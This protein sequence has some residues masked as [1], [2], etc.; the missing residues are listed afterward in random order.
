MTV[1]KRSSDSPFTYG[2]M[3]LLSVLA[4]QAAIAIKNAQLFEEIQQA[5]KKVEESDYLKSEFI[6]I[7]SHELRTPLVSILGY[8]EIL[9]SGATGE[10]LEYLNIVLDQA[11]RLRSVVNDLLSLTDLKAGIAEIV[12]EPISLEAL[13]TKIAGEL[14]AQMEAKGIRLA[15]TIPEECATIHADYE[16]LGLALSKLLSNAI[17]FSP[18]GAKVSVQARRDDSQVVISVMDRGKG[19]PPEAQVNL[20][21]PFYQVE[22]SLRRTHSGMGLG[23]AIAKG[24]IELHG[25]EI[26]VKSEAG[27]GSTFSFSLPQ[28]PSAA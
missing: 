23:L 6:A 12:Q 8:I 11:M 22:E 24:M 14:N 25:G 7:A 26:W 20:F 18:R 21:Q 15:V 10:T 1:G 4:G 28:P 5:Y 3:E 9:A 17:K 13:L 19:I 16:R 2:D 27:K